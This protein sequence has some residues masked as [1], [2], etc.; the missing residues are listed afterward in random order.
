MKRAAEEPTKNSGNKKPAKGHLVDLILSSGSAL[1]LPEVASYLSCQDMLALGSVDKERQKSYA[2]LRDVLLE[3][4]LEVLD[5]MC[6]SDTHHYCGQIYAPASL[7]SCLCGDN[8][9][10]ENEDH[11]EN[12]ALAVLDPRYRDGYETLPTHHK[13]EAMVQFIGTIVSNMRPHLNFTDA[14]NP[15][16]MPESIGSIGN[17]WCGAEANAILKLY[18]RRA[19]L[20]F[21]IALAKFASGA[22]CQ[23]HDYYFN[24]AFLGTGGI[25]SGGSGFGIVLCETIERI[26]P[27]RDEDFVKFLRA[28]L[29]MRAILPSAEI[30]S[31]LG[32]A[33]TKRLVLC[34]PFDDWVNSDGEIVLPDVLEPFDA[35]AVQ[36]AVDE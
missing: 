10:L 34:A 28:I 16:N 1:L 19:A 25:E 11:P 36:R 14:A 20:A 9:D 3:P 2:E 22:M 6:G 5:C 4:T 33:L 26:L 13:V 17:Y 31:T 29:P 30:R 12:Q 24:D 23:G 27:L 7:R 8:M 15:S 32:P 35:A 18:P 21:N